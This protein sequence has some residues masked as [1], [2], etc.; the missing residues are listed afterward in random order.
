M[1]DAKRLFNAGEHLR[2]EQPVLWA[3]LRGRG[4]SYRIA[5][6]LGWPERKVLGELQDLAKRKMVAENSKGT[7][8]LV[9]GHEEYEQHARIRKLYQAMDIRVVEDHPTSQLVLSELSTTGRLVAKEKAAEERTTMAKV[10]TEV[11][12]KLISVAWKTFGVDS[13][14]ALEM[15]KA[16]GYTQAGW[17]KKYIETLERKGF[18][19]L[20]PMKGRAKAWRLT[21][22]GVEWAKK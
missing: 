20:A 9:K 8:Y 6:L 13:F 15:A 16:Q 3:I 5:L 10:P 7:W 19:A 11:Q 1:T 4:S 21:E 14:T 2:A 17:S 12:M 18:V 22:L